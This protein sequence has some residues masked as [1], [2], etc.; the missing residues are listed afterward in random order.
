[1]GCQ[2]IARSGNKATE[3]KLV[4]LV[5]FQTRATP[6]YQEVVKRVAAGEIGLIK[7]AEASYMCDLYFK[8]MDAQFRQSRRDADARL[9]AWAVDRVLSG[10]IIT[11]QNIHALDVASWFLN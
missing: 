11:E 4:F 5:D 7:S 1:A 2:S 8:A 10:D 3:K 9:R 6:A